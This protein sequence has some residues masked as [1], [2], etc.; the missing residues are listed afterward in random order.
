[1]G[2]YTTH[3]IETVARSVNS[4]ITKSVDPSDPFARDQIRL[5]SEHL[6]FMR[7][8]GTLAELRARHELRIYVGMAQEVDA[9]VSLDAIA[10]SI[11][12]GI[13]VMQDPFAGLH[14][15]D[16][17]TGSLR[18]LLSSA[19]RRGIE[20]EAA[21][22][23]MA[24]SAD[25]IALQRWFFGPMGWDPDIDEVDSPVPIASGTIL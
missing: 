19:V 15:I 13:A 24:H 10:D 4:V 18:E 16:R 14:A 11:C 8:R 25:L 20:P 6:R 3:T 2:D 5:V 1:M 12:R 7:E 21:R 23:I 17:A 22:V 9:V